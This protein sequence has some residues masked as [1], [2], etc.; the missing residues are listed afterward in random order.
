MI[1]LLL[2]HP[3]KCCKDMHYHTCARL[4][5]TSS[6]SL[7]SSAAWLRSEQSRTSQARARSR[8]SQRHLLSMKLLIMF[9]WILY[10]LVT[11][12][13]QCGRCSSE[14]QR[15]SMLSSSTGSCWCC[16]WSSQVL[17]T[18]SECTTAWK[19]GNCTVELF[20]N[21]VH[22]LIFFHSKKKKKIEE[23]AR[24]C[25]YLASDATF[26]T[27]AEHL[28]TGGAEL[29]YGDKN[30]RKKVNTAIPPCE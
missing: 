9:A 28:I 11:F 24:L 23:S 10:L 8:L 15:N 14:F 25:L 20:T 7:R 17:S 27:G 22:R 21:N 18:R 6:I 4:R 12:G 3:L 2:L 16:A 30:Q 29:A 1:L 13:R 19:N 26:T 5:A